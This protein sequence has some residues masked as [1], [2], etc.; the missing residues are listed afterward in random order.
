IADPLVSLVIGAL[1]LWSSWGILIE[2]VDVLLE[3]VPKGLDMAHLAEAIRRGPGVRGV[4]DLHVWTISSGTAAC[5][6]HVR[7]EEQGA[8]EGQ[9]LQRAVAEVLEHDFHITHTTIQIEV[10]CCG[11]DDLHCTMRPTEDCRKHSHG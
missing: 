7:V 9:Q 8:R 1:I 6:C 11:D 3:A 5:S 10:E 4:H 2:A